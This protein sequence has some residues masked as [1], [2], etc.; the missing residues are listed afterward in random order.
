[1]RVPVIGPGIVKLKD[2]KMTTKGYRIHIFFLHCGKNGFGA[3]SFIS[4]KTVC[5]TT[6]IFSWIQDPRMSEF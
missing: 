1:M 3:K 6:V 5:F 4:Q 2:Y